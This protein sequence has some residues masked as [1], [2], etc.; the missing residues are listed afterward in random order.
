MMN[1]MKYIVV[2]RDGTEVPVIFPQFLE[3]KEMAERIGGSVIAAGFVVVTS[4]KGVRCYG[5]ST[6]LMIGARVSD[7]DLINQMADFEA[8]D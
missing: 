1:H 8:D 6:T 5:S 4:K 3:H 7:G 2:D